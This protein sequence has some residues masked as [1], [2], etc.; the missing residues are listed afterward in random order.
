MRWVFAANPVVQ[1]D[2]GRLGSTVGPEA[3]DAFQRR[4]TQQVRPGLPRE[5]D[6]VVGQLLDEFGAG[7][8]AL[9]RQRLADDADTA[10]VDILIQAQLRAA[11]PPGGNKQGAK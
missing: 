10:R 3:D 2:I 11:P 4:S 5:A 1:K 8:R 7:Q 6:A 9:A